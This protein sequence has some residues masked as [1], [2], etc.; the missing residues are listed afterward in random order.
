MPVWC[1]S[2]LTTF[3]LQRPGVEDVAVL[4]KELVQVQTLMDKMTLDR[5][6]ESEKLKDECKHLQ[7]KQANSE[8]IIMHKDGCSSFAMIIIWKWKIV[9]NHNEEA[10]F[11][12]E[13]SPKV[14]VILLFYQLQ[15]LY[16]QRKT[17]ASSQIWI[18]KRNFTPQTVSNSWLKHNFAKCYL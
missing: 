11:L 3:Q 5:E 15:L 13:S 2:L 16:K 6:R 10:S 12:I 7:E 1:C 9:I 4:K 17:D 14:L 18:F 8:V